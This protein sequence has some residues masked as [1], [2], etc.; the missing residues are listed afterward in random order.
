MVR[1]YVEE[2]YLPAAR[3]YDKLSAEH[4][5]R[6]RALAEW[7]AAVRTH[8]GEVHIDEAAVQRENGHARVHARIQLGALRPEDVTA[9]LYA[10]PRDGGAPEVVPLELQ[11][12]GGDSYSYEGSLPQDRPPGDFT[13]R[14][15]PRHPDAH[16]P[17]DAPLVVWEH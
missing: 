11:S 12:D 16:L 5:A 9:Q 2:Q 8:W 6:G 7:E 17:L 4:L 3:R 13:L 1:Q 15:L 10:D 14:L